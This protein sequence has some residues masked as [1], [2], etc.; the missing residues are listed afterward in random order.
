MDSKEK[1]RAYGSLKAKVRDFIYGMAGHEMARLA[2]QKRASREHLFFLVTRGDLLGV[3][4]LPSYY[5][6]RLL[7]YVVPRIPPWKR[8]LLREKDLTDWAGES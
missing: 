3:P 8:R 6:R 4:I 1:E 5:S 2:V 7:P